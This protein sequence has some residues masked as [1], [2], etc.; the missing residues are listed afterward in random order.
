MTALAVSA[1]GHVVY[2]SDGA[3][4]WTGGTTLPVEPVVAVSTVEREVW[5]IVRGAAGH[6]LR[7]FDMEGGSVG[8]PVDLGDLGHE[9]ALT[10]SRVGLA[11]GLVDGAQAFE[12]RDR[13]DT[14]VAVHPLGTGG[15]GRRLLL[16]GRGVMERRGSHL[17]PT[18]PSALTPLFLPAAV[19]PYI[20]T[21]GCLVSE[22][23]LAVVELECRGKR[24]LVVYDVRRTALRGRIDLGAASVVAWAE[25]AGHVIVRLGN[26]VRVLDVNVGRWVAEHLVDP[27]IRLIGSDAN[28]SLVGVDACGECRELVM[29]PPALAPIAPSTET[30]LGAASEQDPA[31]LHSAALGSVLDA[32]SDVRIELSGDATE[33]PSTDVGAQICDPVPVRNEAAP[34]ATTRLLSLSPV[35]RAE[36]LTPPALAAY[37]DDVRSWIGALCRTAHC[38]AADS[39]RLAIGDPNAPRASAE[40]E[41]IIAP[42][43]GQAREALSRARTAEQGALAELAKWSGRGVPHADVSAELGLS[44]TATTILML[45]VAPQIWGE[46][47]RAYAIVAASPNRSVVDE[48]LISHLLEADQATR[49][50]IGRELDADA[51]LVRSGAVELGR[52]PRPHAAI[53]VHPSIARRLAGAA[54]SGDGIPAPTPIALEDFIGPRDAI[55]ALTHRLAHRGPSPVRVVIRGRASSGRR[56]LAASLAARAG[57]GLGVVALGG[58]SSDADRTLER[59]L[60][61][62]SLRGDLPCVSLDDLP[63]DPGATAR[64]RA[65]LDGHPGPLFVRSPVSG[66]VPLAPGHEVV[67][68]PVLTES[69]RLY[70]WRRKLGERALDPSLGDK[71]VAT[72]RVGPG[73]ITSACAAVDAH[74]ADPAASITAIMRQHRSSRIG[75]I[76]RRV[77]RLAHWDDLIVPDDIRDALNEVIARVKN[78]R[79]VLESWG[80]DR[81]A[82]TAQGV[83]ALF[84]GGPGTGKTMAVGAIARALGYE[85][86]R[87]DLSKVVSKWIGETEKQL[88]AVFDAAEAGEVV[89]LF[90]EADSLFGKRTDVKSSNDRNANLETNFLLQRLDSFTGVAVLTTNLGTAIDPAFRRRLTVLAQFPFPDEDERARLWRAHLPASVPGA[91][92]VDLSELARRYQL[93]G[94]YIRNAAL[95]AAFLAV[96]EGQPLST[97]H[98]FRSVA[99][100]YQRSGKLGDG[101]L[102]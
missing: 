81:V 72:F 37:L 50:V 76:A 61:D 18:R 64:L 57:R 36:P 84:Q 99:L 31:A 15:H 85:L 3:R 19:Q 69:E 23:T 11:I 10:T 17:A 44:N 101:K 40:L 53:T 98:L 79:T 48:L 22:G 16:G 26:Q 89:L 94:G 27:E 21:S 20:V 83:T 5:M 68:L 96:G 92:D 42:S 77:E 38:A 47:A 4:A 29:R 46:L 59:G 102:E 67:E 93:S 13:G 88:D 45:S 80:L 91:A 65:V 32:P 49:A 78:R 100:E 12:L 66:D 73:A 34:F 51:P 1:D 90:D 33:P 14:T 75:A 56:T 58:A 74:C 28:A 70:C 24:Q 2:M 63:D 41:A 97:A 95:R 43:T 54:S 25:R 60:R 82:T 55:A 9:V 71:L 87:V 7:R 39:G 35:R 86:W 62:V 8:S 30:V 6:V 52:G